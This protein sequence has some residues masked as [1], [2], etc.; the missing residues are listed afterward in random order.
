MQV[1]TEHYRQ[2]LKRLDQRLGFNRFFCWWIKELEALLPHRLRQGPGGLTERVSLV[3][4]FPPTVTI[5]QFKDGKRYEIGR[6]DVS[7]LDDIK[8]K[9]A[10]HVLVEKAQESSVGVALE[11]NPRQVLLREIQL[12][13]AA[14]EN[15]R[16]VLAFEMDRLTPFSHGDVYFDFRILSRNQE[17]NCINVQLAVATRLI[18]DKGVAFL[19][20]M[21]VQSTEVVLIDDIAPSNEKVFNFLSPERRV[22]PAAV[23]LSRTNLVLGFVLVLLVLGAMMLPLVLKRQAVVELN[24]V[25][26]RARVAAEKTDKLRVMLEQKVEEYNFLLEKKQSLPAV[27]E[28]LDELTRLLPDDTWVQQFDVKGKELQFQGETGSSSKLII[29]L[30]QSRLIHEASFRSP[31]TKGIGSNTERFHLVATI[32][33]TLQREA[34]TQQQALSLP[35]TDSV[36]PQSAVQA[37]G[38]VDE[39]KSG[40][41][42]AASQEPEKVPASKDTYTQSASHVREQKAATPPMPAQK[43]NLAPKQESKP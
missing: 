36:S 31:L 39:K 7:S 15:L 18:V 9:Q 20:Q 28:L 33:P 41:T 19:A 23:Q 17:L 6:I 21:G 13:L 3:D 42:E 29:T 11:L 4:F 43:D 35:K 14:E 37:K 24:P 25:V 40:A 30:E 1:R 34:A 10:F 26:E 32:K 38:L 12:P 2:L 16:Q 5:S 22:R 8:L 27:I